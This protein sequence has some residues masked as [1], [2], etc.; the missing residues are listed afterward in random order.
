MDTVSVSERLALLAFEVNAISKRMEELFKRLEKVEAS[1][2]MLA[3][4]QEPFFSPLFLSLSEEDLLGVGVPE[5]RIATVQDT[6]ANN[7]LK[8]TRQ[9]PA[10]AA[11]ALLYYV[12]TGVL[13]QPDHNR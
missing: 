12:A 7:L 6:S 8:L 13:Y 3:E 1:E 11:K 5:D 9:I 4:P 2:Y 10:G